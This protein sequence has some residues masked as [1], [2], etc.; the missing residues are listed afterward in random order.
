MDAMSLSALRNEFEAF[1]GDDRYRKFLRQGFRPRLKF[2]QEQELA[3]FFEARPNLQCELSELEIAFRVCEVHRSELLPCTLE[4]FDG[5]LDYVRSYTNARLELFPHAALDPFSTEGGGLPTQ[6]MSAWFCAQCRQ[7]R[8]QY[9]ANN[10]IQ[11]TPVGA[12]DQ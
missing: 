10:S 12:A 6:A 7:A 8:S 2:W 1:V 5:H 4:V 9:L 11:R 3:R